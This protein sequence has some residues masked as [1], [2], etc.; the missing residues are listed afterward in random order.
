MN[1]FKILTL[2]SSVALLAG[3]TQLAHAHAGF[4]DSA[5]NEAAAGGPFPALKNYNAINIGHGCA[6]NVTAEGAVGIKQK[7]VIALSVLFPSYK[8]IG[9]VILRASKGTPPKLTGTETVITD[10]SAYLVGSTATVP[11][12]VAPT[13]LT[14]NNMFV[15]T[16][17]IW[18]E[19]N[20]IRGWQS[21][22]GPSP[23]KGPVLLES[24]LKNNPADGTMT[25]AGQAPFSIP[26]IQFKPDSCVKT[27]KIRVAVADWCMSGAKNN[28]DPSRV[29]VWIG[30]KTNLFND[31]AIM[32]NPSTNS[33]PIFW[34]TLNVNRDLA[35]N[36]LPGT[37]GF[38]PLK[39]ATNNGVIDRTVTG[40]DTGAKDAN[41]A[42]I[43]STK[44]SCADATDYDTIYIEPS[45]ADIDKYL[46]IPKAKFPKG[47]NGVIYWPTK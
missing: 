36:P 33:N 41:G 1:T 5:I 7:D 6:S 46:P 30:S 42:A 37:K 14:Q 20:N 43:L 13:P 31:D 12:S 16:T 44:V 8:N 24:A 21:W 19:N 9:D 34:P 29:D 25:T 10:F 3:T 45:N 32:P 39:I 47:S 40:W 15:N 11:Y 18:D 23:F 2:C 17:N 27:L 4:K 38:N 22:A 35:L 26:A 28:S